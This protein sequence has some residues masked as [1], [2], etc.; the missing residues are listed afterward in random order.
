MHDVWATCTKIYKCKVP[1]SMEEM[2]KL[3]A[4][5]TKL[6]EE[7]MSDSQN[8]STC[9]CTLPVLGMT[10]TYKRLTKM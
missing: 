7:K 10:D 3:T 1:K 6:W 4:S 9:K 8:E 2:L 5:F